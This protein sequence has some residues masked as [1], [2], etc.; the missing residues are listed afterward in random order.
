M[1]RV[2]ADWRVCIK[3]KAEDLTSR[4]E[5][6]DMFSRLRTFIAFHG[7]LCAKVYL[8]TSVPDG[9][10][11]A[12]RHSETCDSP[13]LVLHPQVQWDF[14]HFSTQLRLL[15]HTIL[16]MRILKRLYAHKR[17]SLIYLFHS[18]LISVSS[19]MQLSSDF[20]REPIVTQY[21]MPG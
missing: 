19:R 20:S 6:R 8:V 3:Y 14:Q 4:M 13:I 11:Q 9:S 5:S 21:L 18:L 1:T 16:C 17:S 7:Q 10:F 12:S 2:F 15:P